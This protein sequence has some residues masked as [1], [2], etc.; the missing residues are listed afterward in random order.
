[1]FAQFDCCVS[2]RMLSVQVP[3]PPKTLVILIY[4][5]SAGIQASVELKTT[6]TRVNIEDDKREFLSFE[7][8]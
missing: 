5:P 7:G 3:L 2:P 4:K 1:M 8:S 6:D